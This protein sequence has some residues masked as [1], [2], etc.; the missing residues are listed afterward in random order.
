MNDIMDIL[1]MLFFELERLEEMYFGGN[2]LQIIKNDIFY[3]V[4]FLKMLDIFRNL[5]EIIEYGVFY[6][7]YFL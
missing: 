1:K 7:F 3:Y 5:I 6:K 2:K 4:K